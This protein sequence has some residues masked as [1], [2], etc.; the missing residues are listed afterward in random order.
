MNKRRVKDLKTGKVYESIVEA[1]RETK[2]PIV[3]GT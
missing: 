3:G 2:E 1:V